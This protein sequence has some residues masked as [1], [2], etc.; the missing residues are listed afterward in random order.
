MAEGSS[1][2]KKTGSA[3]HVRGKRCTRRPKEQLPPRR[4]GLADGLQS[5][6]VLVLSW[7]VRTRRTECWSIVGGSG[8]ALREAIPALGEAIPALRYR[9]RQSP[10]T[11]RQLTRQANPAACYVG[12]K[13]AK[14]MDFFERYLGIAGRGDGS[15][16]VLFLVVLGMIGLVT[17]SY[18]VTKK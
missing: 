6:S 8:T 4:T 18:F 15:M 7:A 14:R 12:D 5:E 10:K 17:M 13:G 2:T 9:S 3:R 11:R 16:E 1:G